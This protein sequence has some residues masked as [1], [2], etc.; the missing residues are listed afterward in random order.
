[1]GKGISTNQALKIEKEKLTKGKYITKTPVH[2]NE[3]LCMVQQNS[4]TKNLEAEEII[5]NRK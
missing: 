4:Q 2:V 5:K 1:M 3:K